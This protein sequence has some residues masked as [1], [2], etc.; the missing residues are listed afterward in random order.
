MVFF[1]LLDS[2]AYSLHKC[3]FVNNTDILNNIFTILFASYGPQD[4]W[5]ADSPFEVM[6]GAILTQN[7]NWANVEKAMASL[8]GVC[9][10]T[11]E[12]I[13]S[14][15]SEQLES[16]IR[17]SGYFRQKAARLHGFCRFLIDEYERDLSRLGSVPTA[18]LRE[19]LLALHGIGPETADSILLYALNRPVFV[20]DAYTIRLLSRLGLCDERGKYHDVQALFMD[21]LESDTETFNEYH[22]LI[23]THCKQRSIKRAPKCGECALAKW[24][25]F[26]LKSQTSNLK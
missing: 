21:N 25:A 9:E 17:P 12:G 26:N 10:L 11:P 15:N 18:R 6:F 22:A 16:V 24:C 1:W 2:I 7:T 13:L 14:L 20:V 3:S 19:M 23:V 8:R 5:P 4:W